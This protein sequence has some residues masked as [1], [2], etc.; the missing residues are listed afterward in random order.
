[1]TTGLIHAAVLQGLGV[2]VDRVPLADVERAWTRDGR[3]RRTVFVP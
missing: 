3:D 2:D 1:M